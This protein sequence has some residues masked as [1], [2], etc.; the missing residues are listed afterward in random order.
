MQPMNRRVVELTTLEQQ[1]K[2][3]GA[4]DATPA[5]RLMMVWPLTLAACNP[6]FKDMLRGLSAANVDFLIVG[7][8]AVAAHGHP[9]ASEDLDI[10]IRAEPETA[11]KVMRALADF[12]APLQDL[13]PTFHGRS[14]PVQDAV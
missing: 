2:D 13:T 11:A 14:H 9:R 12:G 3:A 7:A 8:Y 1:G 5:E 4:P 6:D 10:W